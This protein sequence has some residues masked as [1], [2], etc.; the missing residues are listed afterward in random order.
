MFLYKYTKDKEYSFNKKK[1]ISLD[2]GQNNLQKYNNNLKGYRVWAV[3]EDGT[4]L[5]KDN[6]D[7]YDWRGFL[8][9]YKDEW[10]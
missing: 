7:Q 1:I 8:H 6:I 5:T 9:H 4:I 3:L 10:N 2:R